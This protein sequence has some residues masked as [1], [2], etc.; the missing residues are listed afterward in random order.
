MERPC[1]DYVLINIT[2]LCASAAEP[3][4]RGASLP[5]QVVR[6][7]RDAH[8][9][10]GAAGSEQHQFPAPCRESRHTFAICPNTNVL[11]IIL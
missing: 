4:H 1:L 3:G 7:V 2:F 10:R 6:G 11:N 5:E 9:S 8:S